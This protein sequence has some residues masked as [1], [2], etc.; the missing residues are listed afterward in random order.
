MKDPEYERSIEQQFDCYCK[1][2][3]R[4]HARNIYKEEKRRNERLVSLESLTQKE[5]EQL[6]FIDTYEFD[7]ISFSVL[8]KEVMISDFSIA[9][10]IE[11][12]TKR[13]REIILLSYFLH[14]NNK[15][16]ALLLDISDGVVSRH[17]GKALQDLREMLKGEECEQTNGRHA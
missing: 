15:E 14:M 9:R 7:Y 2:V 11:S 10:A 13:R 4:N 3:L 8:G 17:K 1:K 12:L 5:F 6:Q 16:I